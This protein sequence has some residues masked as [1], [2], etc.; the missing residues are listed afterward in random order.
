[1]AAK[2]SKARRTRS[3]YAE[4]LNE[5]EKSSVEIAREVDGV[6][7]EL[8]VLRLRLRTLA[9]K[10]DFDLSL[11]LRSLDVLRRLVETKHRLS[12][13]ESEAFAAEL[14]LLLT[15]AREILTEVA[16]GSDAGST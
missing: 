5:A 15:E 8:V 7:E 6:G 3:F 16:H 9:K 13:E 2:T 11:L 10:E 1:V 12:K 4:A 14:P